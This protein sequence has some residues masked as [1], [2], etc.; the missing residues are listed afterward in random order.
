VE[1][2]SREHGG[3]RD[4]HIPHGRDARAPKT[5]IRVYLCSS[6]ALGMGEQPLRASAPVW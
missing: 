3:L 2:L 4:Q 1:Q 5:N 6:V